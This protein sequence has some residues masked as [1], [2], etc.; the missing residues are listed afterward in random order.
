MTCDFQCDHDSDHDTQI[1]L[2]TH[3]LKQMEEGTR[4]YEH[5]TDKLLQGLMDLVKS[6][7]PE[8]DM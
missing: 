4:A 1:E 2:N 6:M 7:E 5:N 8:P 3:V